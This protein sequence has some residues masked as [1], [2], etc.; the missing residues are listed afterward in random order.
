VSNGR[1]GWLQPACQRGENR[2][3]VATLQSTPAARPDCRTRRTSS[4]P[5]DAE[6]QHELHPIVA[7]LYVRPAAAAAVAV[8][9]AAARTTSGGG[10]LR[11]L[12]QRQLEPQTTD[13][14]AQRHDLRRQ[15]SHLLCGRGAMAMGAP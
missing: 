7:V 1:R 2:G 15:L 10:V 6:R 8:A 9:A 13:R 11:A 14:C 5:P 4:P 3:D 12:L